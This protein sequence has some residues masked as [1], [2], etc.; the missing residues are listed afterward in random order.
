MKKIISLGFALFCFGTSSILA[1]NCQIKTGFTAGAQVGY[2]HSTGTFNS[3]FYTPFP[4][5]TSAFVSGTN[6]NSS[7]LFGVIGGYREVFMPGYTLGID[8]SANYV[9]LN[10]IRKQFVQISSTFINQLKRTYNIIP[11][12]TLGTFLSNRFLATLSIGM[13]VS[14]FHLFV[15]NRAGGVTV[16]ASSTRVSFAPSLGFE[17][18]TS[19]NISLIGSATYEIYSRVK[20]VYNS[21]V[22]PALQGSNYTTSISPRYLTLKGGFVF[23]F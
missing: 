10:D 6:S 5:D 1:E 15:D 18:A 23:K 2:I 21:R 4:I 20:N 7:A 17:Y 19:G 12:L 22:A 9:G 11:N 3:N 13:G 16:R 8:V 14:R